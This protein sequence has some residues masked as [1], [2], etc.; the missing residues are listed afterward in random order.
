MA[1]NWLVVTGISGAGKTLAIQTLEDMGY[2]CTDNLPPS[3]LPAIATKM[4]DG[5]PMAIVVD[6]RWG[7]SLLQAEASLQALK[8][9]YPLTL[10]FMDCSEEILIRR[11]KETRRPHPLVHEQP[12]LVQAIRL[13]RERLAP[14]RAIADLTLDTTRMRAADLR[15]WIAQE[16]ALNT[17]R[18]RMRIRLISFGFKH[19]MP[20]DADLVFDVRFLKNPHYVPHL[21]PKTGKN[22]DVLTY[23]LRDPNTQIFQQH[24]Y[25]LLDF[26]IP[27]YEREGKAYLTIAIGC[28]GGRHR[29]VAMIEELNRRLESQGYAPTVDHRDIAR[30]EG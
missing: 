17:A 8:A 28:T 9:Q 3:L 24:L 30:R 19:G 11:F 13:E 4:Q 1:A 18:S 20:G 12:D 15:A 6:T 29:S 14:L 25:N 22:A 23:I 26:V 10:L 7:E 2:H 21:Q 27:E 16:F 5:A